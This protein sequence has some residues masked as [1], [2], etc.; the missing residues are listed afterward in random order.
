MTATENNAV[1]L[2]QYLKRE[3]AGGNTQEPVG[4]RVREFD[5][6]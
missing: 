5:G 2:I 6:L 3:L 4:L 1:A